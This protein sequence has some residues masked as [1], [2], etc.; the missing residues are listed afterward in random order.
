MTV[1]IRV[2]TARLQGLFGRRRTG[3]ELE[4]EIQLHIQMLMDRF[5]HRGMEPDEARTAARRQFG[6]ATLVKEHN[7][8]Q[9]YFPIFV[10][11]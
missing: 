1:W 2:F 7:N 8:E 5:I 6:N 9:R 11:L 4:D 3:H 10:T